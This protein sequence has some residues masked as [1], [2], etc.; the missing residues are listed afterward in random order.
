MVGETAL[1]WMSQHERMRN[2]QDHQRPDQRWRYGGY[3]VHPVVK[4]YQP[5]MG[6]GEEVVRKVKMEEQSKVGPEEGIL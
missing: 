5:T 1:L 4:L 3:D 6:L 2:N